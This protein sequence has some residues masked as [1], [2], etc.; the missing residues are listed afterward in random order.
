MLYYHSGII[1]IIIVDVSPPPRAL[2]DI[3]FRSVRDL[4][5]YTADGAGDETQNFRG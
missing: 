5:A 1:V 3:C 2:A 4:H